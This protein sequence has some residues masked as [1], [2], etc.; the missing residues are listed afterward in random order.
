MPVTV[1]VVVVVVVAV[2]EEGL[3]EHAEGVHVAEIK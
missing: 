3:A 2:A 1:L